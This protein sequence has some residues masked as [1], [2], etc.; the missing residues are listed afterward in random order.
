MAKNEEEFVEEVASNEHYD[1]RRFRFDDDY[2]FE[3]Y[4]IDGKK[5]EVI[6]IGER[7]NRLSNIFERSFADSLVTIV[8]ETK[9]KKKMVIRVSSP[10]DPGT[11]YFFDDDEKK[12]EMLGYNYQKVDVESLSGMSPVSYKARDGLDIPSY[13]TIPKGTDGKK[14]PTINEHSEDLDDE[15]PF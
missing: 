10:L 12:L 11:F 4:T 5:T 8:H 1:L 2:N 15:I 6:R 7:G 9:D 3:S 13:L 14:M